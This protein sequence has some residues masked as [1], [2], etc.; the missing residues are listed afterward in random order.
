MTGTWTAAGVSP[1]SRPHS[2][3]RSPRWLTAAPKIFASTGDAGAKMSART[4]VS[5]EVLSELGFV[6]SQSGMVVE[7]DRAA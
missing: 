1:Q 3:P 6:A 4:G 2:T 7:Q 5:V